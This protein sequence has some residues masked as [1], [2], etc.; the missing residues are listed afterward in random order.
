MPNRR[1]AR[2]LPADEAAKIIVKAM[3]KNKFRA[4]VGKDARMPDIMYR[5]APKFAV[6]LITRKMGEMGH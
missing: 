5:I 2:A 1:A 6:D 3:E 4:T